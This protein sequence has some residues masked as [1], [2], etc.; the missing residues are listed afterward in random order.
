MAT[1]EFNTAGMAWLTLAPIMMYDCTCFVPRFKVQEI[2]MNNESSRPAGAHMHV[3]C[4]RLP[5]P[6]NF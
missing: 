1:Q 2:A 3:A 4:S 5:G 6:G